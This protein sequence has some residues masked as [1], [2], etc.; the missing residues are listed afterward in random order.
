[1]WLIVPVVVVDVVTTSWRGDYAARPIWIPAYTCHR[2]A[3]MARS[4]DPQLRGSTA[5]ATPYLRPG[6]FSVG[7]THVIPSTAQ[8][9]VCARGG[10]AWN[11]VTSG[12]RL[13]RGDRPGARKRMKPATRPKLRG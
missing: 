10:E 2:S 12:P 9:C 13:D 11:W 4:S 7:G 6:P 1:M 8:L 3:S 5:S